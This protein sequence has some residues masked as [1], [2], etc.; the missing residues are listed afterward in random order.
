MTTRTSPELDEVLEKDFSYCQICRHNYNNGKKHFYAAKH[1]S[2]LSRILA[3]MSNKVKKKEKSK[4]VIN[5]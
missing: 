3:K 1:V 5:C 2:N 4:L